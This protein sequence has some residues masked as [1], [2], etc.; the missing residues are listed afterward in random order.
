MA[1]SA[2]AAP[3]GARPR[4]TYLVKRLEQAVRSYLDEATMEIGL[5]TPQY[6]ALSSL[7]LKPGLSSAELAR[8][9][10]ISAQAMNQM[11]SAMERK[12]LIRRE[13]APHH[14]RQLRIF[15]TEHGR[16]CLRQCEERADE[17]ERKMFAGLSPAER[18]A[19]ARLLRKCSD[20]LTQDRAAAG[21]RRPAE[22]RS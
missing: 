3:P 10:F 21:P 4:V 18:K 22:A 16:E 5:T 19:V 20:S 2:A 7:D 9:S 15:L 6:A 13:A 17:L 11:V 8:L 1:T 12:N 14:R